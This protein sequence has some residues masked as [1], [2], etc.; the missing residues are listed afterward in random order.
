M[1]KKPLLI[2]VNPETSGVREFKLNFKKIFLGFILLIFFVITILYY[3]NDVYYYFETKIAEHYL[4]SDIN[5]YNSYNHSNPNS[6]ILEFSF[7]D[8]IPK[9]LL[10]LEE[11]NVNGHII[12]K[13]SLKP[14]SQKIIIKKSEENIFKNGINFIQDQKDK[15]IF[16][17]EENKLLSFNNPYRTSFAIIVAISDYDRIHD[18][19]KRGPTGYTPLDFMTRQAMNLT[20]VLKKQGFPQENIIT[21]FNNAAISK[22]IEDSLKLFWDGGKYSDAERIVFYFGGHGDKYNNNH[23]LITYDFDPKKPILSGF[24]SNQL[25]TSH[26]KQIKAKHMLVAIDA[27]NAGMALTLSSPVLDP[28]RIKN[29][30]RLN[31]IERDTKNRARNMLLAGTDDQKAIAINEAIF[32]KFFILALQGEADYNNDGLIQFDEI[33]LY[34]SN[35][36]YQF[37]KINA[38]YVQNPTSSVH[39]AFGNGRILF[40]NPKQFQ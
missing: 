17:I 26:F 5:I 12:E 37:T 11:I 6:E 30:K 7:V 39:T 31:I 35:E 32:T 29:F 27:C 38:G 21:L 40:L 25:I 20:E 9:Q 22:A 28:K 34:L 15:F 2:Y 23:V 13:N 8:T 14:K 4:P 3:S 24:L 10:S 19:S 1:R 16:W 36:V 33:S 18:P